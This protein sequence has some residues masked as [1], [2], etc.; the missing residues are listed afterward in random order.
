ML[1]RRHLRIK[2][3]QALYAYFI[4]DSID[5][6][7]GEKNM[8]NSTG[9]IYELI[10]YQ[11]SFL[12]EI[13]KFAERRIEEGKKKFYPTKEDLDPNTKFIDNRFLKQLAENRDYIRKKNAYKVNW[14]DEE[15]I[16]R[17]LYLEVCS[18]EIYVNYMKSD[19]DNY[20]GD[21]AFILK[22][23]RDIIAYFP[24]LT[25]FYEEKN[26]Y[27]A[28]DIDTAN[29]L[30]LKI[31]KGMKA[32]EDE[33]QPQ[34]SLYN[35]D[36]KADPDEDKKFLIKLY[37]KTILKSKEFEAMIANKTKNWEIDRIATLDIIL[38]KMALT[39]FLEFS[40]IPEKVTMNEYIELSKFYSTPKSRVFINGILD[41]LIIDLKKQKKL[42]KIGRGLIG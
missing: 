7:V 26:I 30:T 21:K 23:F 1:S 10:T 5:L 16:I 8:L 11:F 29:A 41:K 12:L 9:K 39:E 42:V 40:S 36:G 19:T 14:H 15:V 4:S 37:H 35:I 32:S 17:K 13:K 18:S 3:L 27:W 38:I 2:A 25:S 20:Y 24:S 6:P 31:I 34:P 33:F 22:V 28:D